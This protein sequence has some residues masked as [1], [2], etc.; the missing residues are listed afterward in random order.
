MEKKCEIKRKK[1]QFSVANHLMEKGSKLRAVTGHHQHAVQ[2]K[3][4]A[5]YRIT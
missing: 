5:H 2:N 4:T 1:M 3:T